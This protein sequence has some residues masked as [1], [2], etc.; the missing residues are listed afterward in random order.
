MTKKKSYL[1]KA[2]I[3]QVVDVKTE[4]VEV[5][6]WGGVV[7]VGTMS[8][9]DRDAFESSLFEDKTADN[10]ANLTNMR[11]KLVARCIIDEDGERVFTDKDITA[12]GKKSA[13]ALDR[14]YAVAQ[15]LSGLSVKD[16]EE[17]TKN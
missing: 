16:E 5:V 10:K 13:K 7:L 9:V 8:G 17:L 6:E 1:T 2:Q 14:V 3:L 15:R 4:E 11:A 12:L